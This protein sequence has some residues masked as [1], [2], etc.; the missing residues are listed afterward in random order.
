MGY[1]NDGI[2]KINEEF[3]QPCDRVKIQVVG[4]LIQQQDIRI[5]E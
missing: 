4:R 3:F 2:F 1:Y 5:S